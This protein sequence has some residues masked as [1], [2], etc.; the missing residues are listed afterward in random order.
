[1]RRLVVVLV[2]AC[3]S[4]SSKPSGLPPEDANMKRAILDVNGHIIV[5]K[6]DHLTEYRD[7]VATAMATDPEVVAAA[8]MT[9]DNVT[10]RAGEHKAEVLLK[11]IAPSPSAF[12]DDLA[13]YVVAGTLELGGDLPLTIGDDLAKTL[14][15]KIGATVE[16]QIDDSDL[17][18]L[19]VP[20][21]PPP[22]RG[23]IVGIAHL[24]F[25]DYD[26][27]LAITSLAASQK[28]RGIGDVA[29]NVELKLRHED[30][31]IRIARELETRLGG[32]PYKTNDW[33]ELNRA[34]LKC[35]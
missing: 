12:R 32:L 26:G 16:V 4:R 19:Q 3:S 23:R 6:Q 35:D 13:R 24:G 34:L 28:L 11:G 30:E 22:G 7:V 9:F 14:G 27:H 25:S 1:M 29:L 18:M 8:P 15:V 17:D 31:A 20:V 21:A 33:C 2:V 5:V 10:V